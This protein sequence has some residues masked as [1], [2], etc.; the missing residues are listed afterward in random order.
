MPDKDLPPPAHAQARQSA[1]GSTRHGGARGSVGSGSGAT[2]A[3][4]RARGRPLGAKSR[5]LRHAGALGVHHF[6][7]LRAWYLRLDLREAWARYLA[8]AE[9]SSDPRHIAHRRAELLGQVLD[10]GQ[11]L[12]LTLAS[13]RQIGAQLALL[14]QPP[15][16]G[17]STTLPSLDE[18]IAA[19]GLDPEFYTEAELRQEYREFHHLDTLPAHSRH[20]AGAAADGHAQVQALNQIEALLARQPE[21][22]D[23]LDLWL[24]PALAKRLK[25]A[26]IDSLGALAGTVRASGHN[27]FNRTPGLGQTRA[28]ALVDWLAPWADKFEQ[29]IP[30]SARSAPQRQQAATRHALA[31]PACFG[32]VPLSRLAVPA[33]L[34]GG[35][36][37]RG[38]LATHQGQQANQKGTQDDLSAI[39]AWLQ[40]FAAS[41]A[42]H[43]A[44]SK[45]AER[46]YLWCLHARGKALSSVDAA[47]CQAYRAFLGQPSAPWVNA[48]PTPRA[49]P[50]W[51]PFRGPLNGRSQQHALGV[52]LRLFDGLVST[53]HLAAN[54]M[55]LAGQAAPAQPDH[56]AQ[57]RSF[58]GPEWAF[59]VAQLQ[60][61]A[62]APAPIA[63]PMPAPAPTRS[64]ARQGRLTSTVRSAAAGPGP[65]ELRR[66]HLLLAL[67]ADSGLRL[68]ELAGATL[69][70]A[71]GQGAQGRAGA[72]LVISVPGGGRAARQVLVGEGI[73]AL[74]R[75]HHH[76][77][78]AVARL[79]WPTPVVCTLGEQPRQWVGL[80]DGSVQLSPPALLPVRG[81]SASGIY[82][83]LK[84]YFCRISRSAPQAPEAAGV[85]GA[86]LRA[87]STGWLR[88]AGG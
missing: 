19:Q 13:D 4:K 78:Q 56:R 40:Q 46:F 83:T 77:A 45:E 50:A 27:W 81:L 85:S 62:S 18:F 55:R 36:G 47:D 72:G 8:F 28:R 7:F 52:V 88:Q 87:A 24:C 23:R 70:D 11:Q 17:T 73:A 53:G 54:P 63:A 65:A 74:I 39:Q 68:A 43:R 25:A 12:N 35:S 82:R 37:T 30:D 67:L 80:A 3:A 21:A 86:R 20:S 33:A 69:A 16:H 44:Y 1:D 84:R 76:D 66:L 26:G 10:A 42:T 22:A 5:V 14:A 58:T 9:R 71:D 2:P 29:P 51:R 57:T 48:L 32:I 41:Q 49:D 61:R 75:Q 64:L 38:R 60:A 6:A 31:A 79:P 59:V 15:L 34:A